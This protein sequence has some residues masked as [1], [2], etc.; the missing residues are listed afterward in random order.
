MR[1]NLRHEYGKIFVGG[2]V[3]FFYSFKK[4]I[5]ELISFFGGGCRRGEVVFWEF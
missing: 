5:D 3:L 2:F 1:K 4:I